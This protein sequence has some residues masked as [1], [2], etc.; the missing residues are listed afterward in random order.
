[1]E[2]AKFGCRKRFGTRRSAQWRA[3]GVAGLVVGLDYQ[4]PV[5]AAIASEFVCASSCL[6]A[7]LV[8]CGWW[9]GLEGV[10]PPPVGA[11]AQRT[12]PWWDIGRGMLGW[13]RQRSGA[14]SLTVAVGDD[15][16]LGGSGDGDLAAVMGPM[17]IRADQHQVCCK[18][19]TYPLRP[20]YSIAKSQPGVRVP[21]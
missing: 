15:Q 16:I 3:G 9:L 21:R 2:A 13:A 20:R 18:S 14:E 6:A 8:G 10:V 11:L 1:M 4:D 5:A 7:V 12:R 19:L 17:V